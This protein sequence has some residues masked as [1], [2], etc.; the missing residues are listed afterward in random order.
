MKK[1]HLIILALLL[2]SASVFGNNMADSPI[3]N[4][5]EY[6]L[7][8]ASDD[9]E[10][11]FGAPATPENQSETN[12]KGGKVSVA[13][14]ALYSALLPGLGEY[15]MG[16]K[17]KGKV[18]FAAEAVG[19]LGFAAYR[20]YGNWK[21]D[22]MIEFA[23]ENAGAQ[24]EGKDDT[25]EDMVGFYYSR[26]EYNSL[27]RVSDPERPYYPDDP[28]YDWQWVTSADQASYRD[29]KNKSRDAFKK[30]DLVLTL[31]ILNRVVSVI[32]AV[33]DAVRINKRIDSMV[34]TDNEPKYKF[35]INP[36]SR[37]NMVKL[38]L[39]PSF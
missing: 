4:Q 34:D 14:S 12:Y 22:D 11:D 35:S 6:N 32:D 17:T 29:L 20:I 31:L 18:F 27:G 37:K 23:Y 8:F 33:R 19:W 26:E 28:N 2:F 5:M 24:L 38:T 36:F 30:S 9:Y 15:K 21:E 25:F 10:E 13:K 1:Y 39:Y 3:Q 7:L 16:H